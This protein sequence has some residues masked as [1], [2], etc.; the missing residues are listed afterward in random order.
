MAETAVRTL[1]PDQL[2]EPAAIVEIR[3]IEADA[4]KVRAS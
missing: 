3:S 4:V 2:G 1:S